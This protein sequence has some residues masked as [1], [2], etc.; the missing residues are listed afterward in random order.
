MKG[1]SRQPWLLLLHA[2]TALSSIFDASPSRV[3]E[4][5]LAVKPTL[6]HEWQEDEIRK[7]LAEPLSFPQP[8][9]PLGYSKPDFLI[10]RSNPQEL[11]HQPP[12]H[13]LVSVVDHTSEAPFPPTVFE[14]QAGD[15]VTSVGDLSSTSGL[16][17]Q[18]QLAPDHN[19]FS[20]KRKG[21][22]SV[23]EA[24]SYL[25]PTRKQMKVP[26]DNQKKVLHV[27]H[28]ENL[29]ESTQSSQSKGRKAGVDPKDTKILLWR[30]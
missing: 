25:A 2:N 1:F 14:L 11:Q 8:T 4:E 5:A 17:P 10:N 12:P 23:L 28:A 26:K 9:I 16:T 19:H 21:H 6:S 20:R 24:K 7:Y 15:G 3:K 30:F 22:E 27:D 29:P 18:A 13:V